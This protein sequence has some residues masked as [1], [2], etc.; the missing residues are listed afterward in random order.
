MQTLTETPY[1]QYEYSLFLVY[2]YQAWSPF[3]SSLKSG[4]L[5]QWKYKCPMV[6]IDRLWNSTSCFTILQMCAVFTSR[7]KKTERK[8]EKEQK[9]KRE[10]EK[11]SIRKK[12]R[13][14]LENFSDF[15]K[16]TANDHNPMSQ[17]ISVRG[18]S[19]HNR[20]CLCLSLT[21]YNWFQYYNKVK[22]RTAWSQQRADGLWQ[23]AP[24]TEVVM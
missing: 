22:W 24:L 21:G 6:S 4:W 15:P 3:S 10:R 8:K 13:K 18:G 20:S 16:T 7:I 17:S 1:T 5:E 14:K 19:W 12:E 2:K 9:K 23:T 11:E